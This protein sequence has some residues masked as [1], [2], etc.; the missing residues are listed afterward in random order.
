MLNAANALHVSGAGKTRYVA[1]RCA[2]VLRT[3]TLRANFLHPQEAMHGELSSVHRGDAVL[4]MSASGNSPELVELASCCRARHA[5]VLAITL[6]PQNPLIDSSNYTV[7]I[8]L[9]TQGTDT[10]VPTMA[11]ISLMLIGDALCSAIAGEAEVDI[12]AIAEGHPAGT[13][14]TEKGSPK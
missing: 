3:L 7:S 13:F 6:S 2:A 5:T 11:S 8:P 14:F 12:N 9:A 4:L 1:E 10:I